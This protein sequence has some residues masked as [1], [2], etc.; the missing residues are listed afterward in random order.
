MN[1]LC[2]LFA[3]FLVHR[4]FCTAINNFEFSR[5]KPYQ[6]TFTLSF[7]A[8]H[9]IQGVLQISLYQSSSQQ[10]KPPNSCEVKARPTFLSLPACVFRSRAIISYFIV[11]HII[12]ICLLFQTLSSFLHYNQNVQDKWNECSY[13]LLCPLESSKIVNKLLRNS[14]KP[15]ETINS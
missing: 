8:V 1:S 7:V 14:A 4:Q 5:W 2:S 9:V 3:L 11:A 6:C 12:I 13:I 15:H 10:S